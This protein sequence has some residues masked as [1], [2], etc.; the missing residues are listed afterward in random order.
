MNS[1]LDR[2]MLPSQNSLD[3]LGSRVAAGDGRIDEPRRLRQQIGDVQDRMQKT[4]G[5][6]RGLRQEPP[7][8]EPVRRRG[9][10]ARLLEVLSLLFRPFLKL[11]RALFRRGPAAPAP[12]PPDALTVLT[13]KLR[14]CWAQ[15]RREAAD[16]QHAANVATGRAQQ[17]C[18]AVIKE[19]QE[20]H[21]RRDAA[22]EVHY[23]DPAPPPQRRRRSWYE[24]WRRAWSAWS[25][26]VFFDKYEII[27]PP[28][29]EHVVRVNDLL[30]EPDPDVRGARQLVDSA[31]GC[32]RQLEQLRQELAGLELPA[33]HE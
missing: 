17:E 31:T 29:V 10:V 22:R 32:L 30:S 24:R 6:V 18:T 12:P 7:P 8:P 28:V 3:E 15:R 23:T 11:W 19:T 20:L 16:E 33:G 13:Q 2:L 27:Q 26:R 4:A 1:G 21:Q 5:V 9:L 14:E 25:L